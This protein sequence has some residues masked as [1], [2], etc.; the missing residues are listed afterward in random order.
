MVSIGCNFAD[1]QTELL[2]SKLIQRGFISSDLRV[3][4]LWSDEFKVDL[5]AGFD[6]LWK[7]HAKGSKKLAIARYGKV[8]KK[9]TSEELEAK[10]SLYVQTNDFQYLKGLDV[11]LNPKMEHWNDPL[12]YKDGVKPIDKN[13]KLANMVMSLIF[14]L[15]FVSCKPEI[16]VK[17]KPTMIK[18][19]LI[20]AIESGS[21]LTK[22]DA[23]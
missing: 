4:S 3:S 19:E 15:V 2:I 20:D 21:K 8:V 9:I 11:Y 6:A 14:I 22:A 18:S 5:S 23:G 12:V 17:E 1:K 7:I 13:N 10:L 16:K